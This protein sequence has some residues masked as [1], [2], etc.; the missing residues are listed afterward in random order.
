[1]KTIIPAMPAGV[2]TAFGGCLGE[3]P[4]LC[5]APAGGCSLPQVLLQ[6]GV[7]G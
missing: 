3:G 2:L 5:A 6:P 4:S 7:A 1:M